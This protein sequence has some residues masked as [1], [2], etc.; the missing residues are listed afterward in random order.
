MSRKKCIV[1]MFAV[2]AIAGCSRKPSG[3]ED[4]AVGAMVS[5]KAASG[6]VTIPIPPNEDVATSVAL[7]AGTH[8]VG[9]RDGPGAF[10]CH[11]LTILGQDGSTSNVFTNSDMPANFGMS[12]GASAGNG[13]VAVNVQCHGGATASQLVVTPTP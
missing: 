10:T 7:P 11:S 6:A 2:L 1:V 8:N 13:Y 3:A 5:P 12:Q 4:Q 9:F